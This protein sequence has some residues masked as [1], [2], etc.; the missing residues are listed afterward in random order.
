VHLRSRPQQAFIR[1]FVVL[2]FLLVAIA[3]AAP[4][5]AEAAGPTP[6][7]LEFNGT[8]NATVLNSFLMTS[9]AGTNVPNGGATVNTAATG[10]LNI[11]SSAGDLPPFGTAQDNALGIQY[12]SLGSYTIGARLLK[13]V[14][15]GPFQSAGIYL[16]KLKDNSTSSIQYIRYTVGRGSKGSTGERLELDVLESNGKLRSSVIPLPQGTLASINTSLDLFLNIDHTGSGKITALYRIDSDDV[17]AGRL[18]TSRNFPRWLRQGNSVSVYAGVITTNRGAPAPITISYDWFRLTGDPQVVASV[19]GTKTV[20][21]DGV[22]PA[23]NPED[24]LTYTV[25]ITNNGAATSVQV[26]DP[27]PIDTSYVPNSVTG[28]AAYDAANNQIVLPSTALANKAT[29]QFTYQVK[30]NPAPLQSSTIVNTAELTYGASTVPALLSASTTVGITPDLGDSIYLASPAAVSPN[31]VVTFTLYLLNNGTATAN[32][33]TA[34]LYIPSGTTLVA[35]SASASSGSLN[36]DPSLA[37][38][39]WNAAGPLALDNGVTISFA[40][41]VGSGFTNGATLSSRAVL[42]ATGTLPNIVTAQAIYSVPTAIGGIKTVDKAQA[43]PGAPLK[44]FISVTNTSGAAASNLQVVD[45]I[46]QDTSYNANLSATPG[47]G[48]PTYDAA[49]NQVVWPIPSLAAGQ[50]ISMTFQVLINAL[51][52]HLAVITNKAV[53]TAPGSPQSL[54]SASTI[55]DGVA[56]L[57]DSVYTANPASVG[58]NGTITYTLN[59]LNDGTTAATNATAEFTIPSGVTFV[60]NSA[61][62]TSGALNV[63]TGLNKISW[64]AGGPLPIGSVT[65]ISFQVK[66]DSTTTSGTFTSVATMQA[67]GTVPNV[68]TA[69]SVFAQSAPSKIFIYLPIVER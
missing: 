8:D 44:Y 14:F 22:N 7:T 58:P 41:N 65:R 5:S 53:L 56:D 19:T 10:T 47:A 33:A 62:A 23:V 67:N 59:L 11:V 43:T 20:D 52:L 45:P 18:A 24:T 61:A 26:A 13:P 2:T 69:Q 28:G 27:I 17:N 1:L 30:I 38:I 9:L 46:P 37:T 25:N 34:Q 40:V 12:S 64:T 57:S 3:G 21:R 49:N 15:A 39:T 16:G 42:Q 51:P 54:L 36:I 55:V 63:N 35:N 66:L 48:T 29:V 60:A 68:E 6:V 32:G 4:R 50:S 31:G